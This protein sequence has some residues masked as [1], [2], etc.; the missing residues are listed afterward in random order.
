VFIRKTDDLAQTNRWNDTTT[1]ANVANTL[2]GFTRDW[3]FATDGNA[4]LECGSAHM[5]KPES[6]IP[7]AVHVQM[8][9]KMI[10]TG[11][12]NSAMKP[13]KSMGE[14]RARI[15]NMM[16]T[17]KPAAPAHHNINGRYAMDT[18]TRWRNDGLN[19][20]MQFLGSSTA[21]LQKVM[22]QRNPN[23]LML[24]EMYQI[25]MDT[26]RE[27]RPKVKKMITA[28]HL[29]EKATAMRTRRFLPSRKGSF[30]KAWIKRKIPTQWKPATGA[31][32]RAP[33]LDQ[34]TTLTRTANI[35]STANSRTTLKKIVLKESEKR[36]HAKTDS[37]AP[38][39]QSVYNQQQWSVRKRFSG[40]AA[41]FSL[42]SLKTPLIQAPSII[43]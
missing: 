23:T 10:I 3:L 35:V 19:N 9:E 24:D 18:A 43:S 34:G 16:V 33:N 8:D 21:D 7:E 42:K 26:Q 20:A 41:G 29:N 27:S 5:D 12:S 1:Y 17:L 39:G 2:K 38:I 37:V 15:I 28:D 22:A 6:R 25:A 30:P 31:L 36:N 4:R 13:Y 32:P 14:L 40:T 11:L